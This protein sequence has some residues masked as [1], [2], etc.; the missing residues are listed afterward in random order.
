MHAPG[1]LADFFE[2]GEI[3]FVG[4]AQKAPIEERMGRGQ[5][6]L[7]VAIVLRLRV[8]GVARPDRAHSA[9]PGQ[10]L[11]K[12][13][14]ELMLA[15]HGIERLD[16]PAAGV[17]DDVP[18]ISQVLLQ[19]IERSQPVQG[20][21]G[22]VGIANPAVAII[23]VAFASRRLRDRGRQRRDDRACFFVLTQLER[24]RAADHLVLPFQRD[25][26]PANPELPVLAGLLFHVP[27][28]GAQVADERLVRA[29]KEVLVAFD[30]VGPA[31]EHVADRRIGRKAQGLASE[32]VTNMVRAARRFRPGLAV[33]VH[34]A[35]VDRQPRGAGHR[36]DETGEG[37]RPVHPARAFEARAEVGDFD[38]TAV[39]GLEP[40]DKYR[41]VADI[42]LAGADLPFE[43]EPPYA[44]I[45][46]LAV[47][48]GTEYGIAVDARH[49]SPY[50]AGG[51][52]DQRR[53]LTIADWPQFQGWLF[54]HQRLSHSCTSAGPASP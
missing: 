12:A 46:T 48:E 7:T 19:N 15:H 39:F 18:E 28:L 17:V 52:I 23:P 53:N 40:R 54:G 3:T 47:E 49:A 26:Q 45:L 13:F 31:F 20:L 2:S 9:I 51:A 42:L 24:D 6:D 44:H 29:E 1:H 41:R 37:D 38:R 34:R 14:V 50:Q 8:G 43:G 11:G 25:G 35:E 21:H 33:A 32:Q 22:V 30:P 4:Y 36:A 16:L 5:N 27:Q 10:V